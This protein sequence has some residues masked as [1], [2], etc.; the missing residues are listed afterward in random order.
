MCVNVC[1]YF[2]VLSFYFPP[3]VPMVEQCLSYVISLMK[4]NFLLYQF[5]W[6]FPIKHTLWLL[7][8]SPKLIKRIQKKAWGNHGPEYPI[9][10]LILLLLCPL[11]MQV[12]LSDQKHM[13]TNLL[14]HFLMLYWVYLQ[15]IFI[16]INCKELWMCT[17]MLGKQS[18][19]VCHLLLS[20]WGTDISF[21]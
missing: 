20:L 14:K 12:T 19:R 4:P 11:P 16:F 17:N 18:E 13:H 15:S 9:T 3:F 1:K 2:A 6:I 7:I 8:H 21:L 10:G 5:L